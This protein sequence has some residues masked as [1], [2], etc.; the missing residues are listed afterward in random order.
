MA[1]AD[2]TFVLDDVDDAEAP[3]DLSH[4]SGRGAAK[5]SARR[6]LEVYLEKKALRGRLQD[7]FNDRSL[8]LEELG[9]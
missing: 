1:R 7:T 4:D 2:D 5:L 9:W 6:S 3:V 8:D